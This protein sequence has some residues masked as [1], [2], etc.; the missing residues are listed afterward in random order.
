MRDYTI[1]VDDE[2]NLVDLTANTVTEGY[3]EPCDACGEFEA[4][5][6]I[7]E[8]PVTSTVIMHME[9][10]VGLDAIASLTYTIEAAHGLGAEEGDYMSFIEEAKEFAELWK[11]MTDL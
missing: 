3:C 1:R 6:G 8:A 9:G 4:N 2:G 10:G 5:D 11:A 7:E